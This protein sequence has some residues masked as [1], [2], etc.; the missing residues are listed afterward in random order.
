MNLRNSLAMG[1]DSIRTRVG[2]VV[3]TGRM[4]IPG[5]H[6]LQWLQRYS[7]DVAVVNEY[8]DEV[9]EKFPSRGSIP[10]VAPHHG[11]GRARLMSLLSSPGV[12]VEGSGG[13]RLLSTQN[14]SPAAEYVATQLRRVGIDDS[15]VLP[16]NAYPWFLGAGTKSVPE[17]DLP[18]GEH[19][20]KGLLHHTPDLKVVIV[21]G[22]GAP[23]EIWKRVARYDVARSLNPHVIFTYSP[24]PGALRG[25]RA[26]EAERRDADRRS[27]FDRAAKLL[28]RFD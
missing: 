3:P 15:D 27:A 21:Q 26:S 25:C 18:Y 2:G 24:G 19:A 1:A 12:D 23:A 28:S 9:R 22:K 16:W 5:Y 8:V 20:L 6:K 4:G 13:S 11:G 7:G 14:D 10:Y 17:N